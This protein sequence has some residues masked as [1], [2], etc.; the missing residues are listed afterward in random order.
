MKIWVT[1]DIHLGHDNVIKYCKRPFTPENM[2]EEIIKKWNSIIQ[3]DDIVI[4]LGDMFYGM[5]IYKYPHTTKRDWM[6][7]L[8][9]TQILVKGNHDEEPDQYYLDLGFYSVQEYLILGTNFFCHYPVNEDK[10]ATKKQRALNKVFLD[11]GCT[12]L[13]HGHIHARIVDDQ[14]KR[15]TFKHIN[16]CVDANDFEPILLKDLSEF[17][18]SS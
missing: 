18:K 10:W 9:G 2:D 17:T 16:C 1:S 8:N 11:S 14:D 5:W 15:N 4:N 7:K 6:N 3:P 13:Y 12:K